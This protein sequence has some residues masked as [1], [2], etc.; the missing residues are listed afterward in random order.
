MIQWI[1]AGF[2]LLSGMILDRL[3]IRQKNFSSVSFPVNQLETGND[4]D[5]G[6]MSSLTNCSNLVLLDI[7]AKKLRG[8]LPNSVGNL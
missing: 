4:F 8:E 5:W 3:G 2:N 1:Q 7:G 6:L